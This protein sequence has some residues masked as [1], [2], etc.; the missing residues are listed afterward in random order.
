M[1]YFDS[2]SGRFKGDTINFYK[3]VS[4]S[5]TNYKIRAEVFDISGR[6]LKLANTAAGG[7][8]T[9]IKVT[10]ATKGRFTVKIPKGNLYY[11]N[12]QSWIEIQ[13]ESSIGQVFTLDKEYLHTAYRKINWQTPD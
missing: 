12:D 1:S 13:L 5:L 8:D 11:W 7:S 10:D 9:Q 3:R 2:L 4:L 6:S